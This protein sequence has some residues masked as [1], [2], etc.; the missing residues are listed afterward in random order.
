M[1]FFQ[2]THTL[3]GG[4]RNYMTCFF[5]LRTFSFFYG[6]FAIF[7]AMEQSK[8]S[9]L[10]KKYGF[11]Y[12]NFNYPYGPLVAQG[13]VSF[14]YVFFRIVLPYLTCVF[15]KIKL[16]IF[17]LFFIEYESRGG[18]DV[19]PWITDLEKGKNKRF[20]AETS[21]TRNFFREKKMCNLEITVCSVVFFYKKKSLIYRT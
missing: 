16:T 3:R 18:V 19:L 9:D 2:Q 1:L 17:H 7:F 14:P 8:N 5:G 6:F 20:C 10:K 11:F 21:K 4:A 13:G 12:T 15:A